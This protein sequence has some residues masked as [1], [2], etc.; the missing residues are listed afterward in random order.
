MGR[1]GNSL[2]SVRDP[3]MMVGAALEAGVSSLGDEGVT[4]DGWSTIGAWS[5]T[6]V[7]AAVE[8]A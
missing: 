3:W 4:G 5:W 1:E 8:T 2:N 6:F 7:S